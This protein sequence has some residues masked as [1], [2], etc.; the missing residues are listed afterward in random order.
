MSE[1][2]IVTRLQGDAHDTQARTRIITDEE[3]RGEYAY[4]LVTDL[5]QEMLE[6]GLISRDEF[7]KIDAKNR[8][9]F[10]PHLAP[11]MPKLT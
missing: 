5:L 4:E 10:S 11:L 3:L 9:S 1:E 6:K 7:N 2:R 8:E